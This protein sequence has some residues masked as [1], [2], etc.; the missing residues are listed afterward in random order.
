MTSAPKEG[1]RWHNLTPWT[2]AKIIAERWSGHDW[3]KMI[4]FKMAQK[5]TSPRSLVAH[6]TILCFNPKHKGI[7]WRFCSFAL[8]PLCRTSYWER[9]WVGRLW[10]QPWWDIRIVQWAIFRGNEGRRL[11]V[12]ETLSREQCDEGLNIPVLEGSTRPK[13]TCRFARLCGL[14]CHVQ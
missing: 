9:I 13:S 2:H 10:Q 11:W 8:L 14:Q 5:I 1:Q 4:W 6:N 12:W 7:H 3:S